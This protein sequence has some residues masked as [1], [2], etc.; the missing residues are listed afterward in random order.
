MVLRRIQLSPCLSFSLPL[1]SSS[2]STPK[3]SY[4]LRKK[5]AQVQTH[6]RD[7]VK[8][9]LKKLPLFPPEANQVG[10]HGCFVQWARLKAPSQEL[11][12][13][14]AALLPGPSLPTTTHSQLSKSANAAAMC[15]SLTTWSPTEPKPPSSCEITSGFKTLV[16]NLVAK[17]TSVQIL[18]SFPGL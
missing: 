10:D 6:T 3:D 16:K 8:E 15:F 18:S 13:T 11:L 14:Q 7:I 17:Q 1:S 12:N 9:K 2:L 5:F 4:S